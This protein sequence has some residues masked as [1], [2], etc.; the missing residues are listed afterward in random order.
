ML[1]NSTRPHLPPFTFACA[2]LGDTLKRCDK[3]HDYDLSGK[4]MFGVDN[5]LKSK[6][7]CLELKNRY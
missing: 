5:N 3:L 6:G 7:L 2:V 1:K 4:F